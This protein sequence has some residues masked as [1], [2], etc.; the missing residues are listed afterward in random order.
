ME[1][2]RAL[3]ERNSALNASALSAPSPAL[4]RLSAGGRVPP[5][6]GARAHADSSVAATAFFTVDDETPT[7]RGIDTAIVPH[8]SPSSLQAAAARTATATYTPAATREGTWQAREGTR[9]AQGPAT[10]PSET[11]DPAPLRFCILFRRG[12]VPHNCIK[13]DADSMTFQAASQQLRDQ[14]VPLSPCCAVLC[15]AVLWCAVLC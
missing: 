8:R 6:A 13:E 7:R 9:H 1:D 4:G 10:A 2:F 15:C 3:V 14:Y 5:P 12:L 11:E